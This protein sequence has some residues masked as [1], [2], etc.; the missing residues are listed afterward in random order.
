[1]SDETAGPSAHK[2]VGHTPT[3][4]RLEGDCVVS[5]DDTDYTLVADCERDPVWSPLLGVEETEANAQFIVRAC[6]SHDDLLEACQAVSTSLGEFT[7]DDTVDGMLMILEAAIAKAE[8]PPGTT[9]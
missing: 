9:P 5:G 2:T 4:W 8:T 7:Q 1:M 6:N 3:P